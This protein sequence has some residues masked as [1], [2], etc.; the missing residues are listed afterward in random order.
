MTDPK[1][2]LNEEIIQL[3]KSELSTGNLERDFLATQLSVFQSDPRNKP[4]DTETVM[5]FQTGDVSVYYDTGLMYLGVQK[6]FRNT[7]SYRN[8]KG[9]PTVKL[10]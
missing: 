3:F 5:A 2:V 9:E 6:T 4:W 10:S 8:L 1:R 7:T